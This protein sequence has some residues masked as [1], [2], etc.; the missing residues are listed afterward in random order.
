M[1]LQ[2]ATLLLDTLLHQIT[3]LQQ[4]TVLLDTTRPMVLKEE[5]MDVVGTTG[6][7]TITVDMANGKMV[8]G[9]AKQFKLALFDDRAALDAIKS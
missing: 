4:A 2:Q 3:G 5:K 1:G 8:V 6:A 9:T 7:I